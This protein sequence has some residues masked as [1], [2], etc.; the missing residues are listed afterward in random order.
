[1]TQ[2]NAERR[3]VINLKRQGYDTFLP[4]FR[5][6][7]FENGR[8]FSRSGVLFSRY[9]FVGIVDHWHSIMGTIGVSNL[10]RNGDKPAVI[11]AAYVEGLRA[12]LDTE[13]FIDLSAPVVQRKAGDVVTVIDGPF[14]GFHGIYEGMT[15]HQ[16]EAVLLD[17]L[18][19]K[20]RVVLQPGQ[21][22]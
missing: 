8:R 19:R 3:A 22:A 1:M 2:P 4:K 20:V 17:M 11:D 5:E 14:Y 9:V 18:G 6:T 10:I 21:L 15:A 13:G 16:R 7:V 12:R